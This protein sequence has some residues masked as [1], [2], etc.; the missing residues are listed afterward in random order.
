MPAW[1][2][3]RGAMRSFSR[4]T[5]WWSLAASQKQRQRELNRLDEA[6]VKYKQKPYD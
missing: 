4:R 6:E 3:G 1:S 5:H 2:D